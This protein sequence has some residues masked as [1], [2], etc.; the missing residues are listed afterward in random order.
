VDYTD[1]VHKTG[2]AFFE[3][4]VPVWKINDKWVYKI[5]DI[6]INIEDDGYLVNINLNIG[7]LTLEVS[8]VSGDSYKIDFTIEI[9]GDI[10]VDI[11]YYQ[12]EISADFPQLNPF[13][14]NGDISLR[15]S[16]LGIKDINAQI[17]GR[18]KLKIEKNPFIPIPLPGIRV[19]VDIELDI[20]FDN[21]FTLIDFPLNA[22]KVWGISSNTISVDGNIRSIWLNIIN[23]INTIAG[24][25]GLELIPPKFAELLPTIDISEALDA[26]GKGSELMIPAVDPAFGC[27]SMEEITVEVGTYNAY[28]III[29]QEAGNFYYSPEAGNIIKMSIKPGNSYISNIDIE[30]KETNYK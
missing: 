22:S 5:E 3:D 14:I 9:S 29:A 17:S 28:N 27:F 11:E 20:N 6:S 2:S 7:D 15:K 1:S 10:Y 21:P 30:L 19:P 8:D 25:F 18:F 26:I 23:L 12:I 13:E 4:D 24:L 16:D